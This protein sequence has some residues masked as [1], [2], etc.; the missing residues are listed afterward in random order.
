MFSEID[1]QTFS[2]NPFDKIGKQW[3]LV[4]A[5]EIPEE[6]SQQDNSVPA[7]AKRWNTLT[8]SWG[9]LGFLWNKPVAFVFIRKSRYTHEFMEQADAFTCSFFPE[10]YRKALAFCGSHSG[11][12]FDK[13]LE[14]GITPFSMTSLYPE[15]KAVGFKEAETILTCKKLYKR[16]LPISEELDP[17]IT[18]LYPDSD[19]HS[20]YIGEILHIAGR[21]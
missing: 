20:M 18:T 4:S 19:F 21:S 16:E 1:I 10:Q 2:I 15:L 7:S 11:R 8:A 14:T 5:G 6:G 17:S 12:E 3:M 9:G 13:A